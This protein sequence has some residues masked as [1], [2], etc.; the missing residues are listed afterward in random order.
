MIVDA[1]PGGLTAAWILVKRWHK[2]DV[3]EKNDRAGGQFLIAAYPPGKGE[4]TKTIV[5]LLNMCKKYRVNIH[6]NTE[7]TKEYIDKLT[8]DAIILA[9]GAVALHPKQLKE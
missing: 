5:Y 6:Y 8:P 1:G 7:I 4:S 3:Y 2:V 9:T